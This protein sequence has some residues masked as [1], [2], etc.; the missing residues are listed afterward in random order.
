L[1]KRKANLKNENVQSKLDFLSLYLLRVV[2][3]FD[4]SSMA[5]AKDIELRL[6]QK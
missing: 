2:S 4:K 1:E 5:G 6:L 3:T